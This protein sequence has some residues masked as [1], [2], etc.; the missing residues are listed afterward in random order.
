MKKNNVPAVLI[1]ASI[2]LIA[3]NAATTDEFDNGFWMQT[4]SGVL[5]ILAMLLTIRNRNKTN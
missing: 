2:L 3:L 1:T 4:L 5:L